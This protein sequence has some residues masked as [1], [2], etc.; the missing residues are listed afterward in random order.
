MHIYIN[1]A[2]A[3]SRLLDFVDRALKWIMQ[4]EILPAT[5]PNETLYSLVS[6]I[7]QING[8][9]P[10]DTLSYLFGDRGQ[11]R[12]A[13]VVA[14]LNHFITST[15]GRYGDAKDVLE[16]FTVVPL[17][18]RL[19]ASQAIDTSKTGLCLA[20]LSNG[21]AHIWRWCTAC[22]EEDIR[23]Y[24]APYWHRTHQLPGVAACTAHRTSL[25]EANIPFRLRQKNFLLPG[26]LPETADHYPSC[27]D[28]QSLYAAYAIAHFA[29]DA[30][31]DSSSANSPALVRNVIMHGIKSK[32][33]TSSALHIRNFAL[34]NSV[35]AHFKPL[36][37]IQC[38]ES[39]I[40]EKNLNRVCRNLSEPTFTQ[41]SVLD[42]LLL[43]NW[44]YGTW[45]M[46]REV[47]NWLRVIDA[48]SALPITKSEL[49]RSSRIEQSDSDRRKLHRQ[50]CIDFRRQHP[51]AMRTQFWHN[52][53]KTCRWLSHYDRAWF[54]NAFPSAKPGID[55]QGDLFSAE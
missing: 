10:A 24:G 21:N 43:S 8:L 25:I 50:I 44:L 47:C 3:G 36:A 52:H 49:D 14:D 37:G 31:H 48:E 17:L 32:G 5:L 1:N 38:L 40:R 35:M 2:S 27:P 22:M 9:Y 26:N 7:S 16:K 28:L 42:N 53:S 11:P 41:N 23:L 12:I 39:I 13:D 45:P 15:R 54:E 55:H 46:F 18:Q 34:R 20:T 33:L 19:G 6:R 30:L 4:I 51:G 29:E